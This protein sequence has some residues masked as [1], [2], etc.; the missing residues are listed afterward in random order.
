MCARCTQPRIK[1]TPN[2]FKLVLPNLNNAADTSEISVQEQLV[3]DFIAENGFATDA[4]IRNLLNIKPTRNFAIMKKKLGKGL[5]KQEGIG[6]TK[7][8]VI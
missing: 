1:T 6:A 5:V 8:F 7:R 4:D 2:A 3:P